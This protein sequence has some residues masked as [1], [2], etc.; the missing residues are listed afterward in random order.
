MSR[1]ERVVPVF[2]IPSVSRLLLNLERKSEFEALMRAQRGAELFKCGGVTTCDLAEIVLR[3]NHFG[4][5][6]RHLVSDE[7]RDVTID[8]ATSFFQGF[9]DLGV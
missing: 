1:G 7:S 9:L 2:S 3:L 5:E 4:Y 8:L 6:S